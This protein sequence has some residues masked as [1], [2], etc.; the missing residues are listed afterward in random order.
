MID[1]FWNLSEEQLLQELRSDKARGLEQKE[2]KGRLKVYGEN[3]LRAKWSKGTLQLIFAQINSPLIYMLLFAATISL[4]LYAKTDAMIIFGIII[5][6]ALLSF[7]Q[8]R[9]ALKSMEK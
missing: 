5:A 1:S 3:V 8:E 4:L 9:G 6:S 2:A 7:F